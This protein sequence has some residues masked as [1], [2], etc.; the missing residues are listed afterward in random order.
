MV[1]QRRAARPHGRPALV[2]DG[3][4]G[5]HEAWLIRRVGGRRG[6]VG[7]DPHGRGPTTSRPGVIPMIILVAA[8]TFTD[9]AVESRAG[10]NV[11]YL[12]VGSRGDRGADAVPALWPDGRRGPGSW[13]A[14]EGVGLGQRLVQAGQAGSGVAVADVERWRDV[15]AVAQDEWDQTAVETCLDERGHRCIRLTGGTR[16]HE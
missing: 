10:L 4:G 16:R 15:D 3:R 7:R 14:Q 11:F 13:S 6:P 5:V 12:G 8:V 9:V 2:P 1:S